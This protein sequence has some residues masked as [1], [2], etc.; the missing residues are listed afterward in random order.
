[1]DFAA[2]SRKNALMV[3]PIRRTCR[4]SSSYSSGRNLTVTLPVRPALSSLSAL[5]SIASR[6]V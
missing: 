4:K 6:N 1:M 3:E 5:E 2:L